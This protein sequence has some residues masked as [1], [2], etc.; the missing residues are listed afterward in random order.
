M[1]QKTVAEQYLVAGYRLA[2][3]LGVEEH[4]LPITT[5]QLTKEQDL[6]EGAQ[7]LAIASNWIPK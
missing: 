4:E 6:V 2:V 7:D 3:E 1:E 5:V